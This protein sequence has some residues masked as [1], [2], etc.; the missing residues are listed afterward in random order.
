MAGI[1]TNYL[2]KKL[3]DHA[4]GI[5]TFTMPSKIYVGLASD[6]ADPGDLAAGTLTDEITGY[7]SNRKEVSFAAAALADNQDVL[8]DMEAA[9]SDEVEF[10]DMPECTVAWAL[11]CDTATGGNLLWA[12]PLVILDGENAG[13]PDP[14]DVDEGATFRLPADKVIAF[15]GQRVEVE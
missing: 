14:K 12:L 5:A 4:L 9:S 6:D 1:I 13:N 2:S 3:L 7:D 10:E 11:I 8:S 15:I